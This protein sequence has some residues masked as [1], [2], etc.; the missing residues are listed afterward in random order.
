[1]INSDHGLTNVVSKGPETVR[2]PLRREI[3][4]VNPQGLHMRP[5][6]AFAEKA[7]SFESSVIVF[8][9]VSQPVDGKN[10]LELLL[11]AAEPGTKLTLEVAGA[12]A[13]DALAALAEILASPTPPGE[14]EE[15]A[16]S[17]G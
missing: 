15:A 7:G 13:A 1:M 10:W 9:D 6:A 16:A 14:D 11:L 12:D 4:I 2:E 5:A 17:Q 3:T 8:R